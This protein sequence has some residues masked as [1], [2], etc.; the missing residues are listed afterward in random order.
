MLT[1]I[2]KLSDRTINSDLLKHLARTSNDE[3]PGIR[4]NTTICLGKIARS[5]GVSTRSKVLIAAFTRSLRDPFVHARNASLMALAA[6]ADCFSDDDIAGKILPAICPLL[7]DKEKLVRDQANKSL[8]I[9]LRQVR[10]VAAQMADSVL[11]PPAPESASR[12]NSSATTPR[13]GTPQPSEAASWTGWAISSFTNKLSTAA[14][15][16]EASGTPAL[17]P[18][19]LPPPSPAL[20]TKSATLPVRASASASALHRQAITSPGPTSTRTSTSSA[21]DYFA[22]AAAAEPDA[23]EDDFEAWGAM[24]DDETAFADAVSQQPAAAAKPGAGAAAAPF[25][26]DG[27]EPDFAGWLAAQAGKKQGGG[28]P[29]PKGLAKGR[30]AAVVRSSTTGGVGPGAGARKASGTAALRPGLKKVI[31]T[32]PKEVGDDDGWGDGW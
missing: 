22:D 24:D 4:T 14:G 9:Y 25:A 13:M 11:P 10:K 31:D 28:K 7:L 21:A 16:I 27:A 3:Q 23:G 2:T 6:T 8:D 30:P 1:I 17:T 20:D 26:D 29:L 32:K 18:N 19:G 5:L 12:T 15:D